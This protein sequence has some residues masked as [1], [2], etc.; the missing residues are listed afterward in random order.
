MKFEIPQNEIMKSWILLCLVMIRHKLINETIAFKNLKSLK[1][2]ILK[3]IFFFCKKL[4]CFFRSQKNIGKD[5]CHIPFSAPKSWKLLSFNG[6]PKTEKCF[7]IFWTRNISFPPSFFLSSSRE[8]S[9]GCWGRCCCCRNRLFGC[10]DS[11]REVEND[12]FRKW[13]TTDFFSSSSPTHAKM[14]EPN[15]KNKQG[16]KNDSCLI[17]VTSTAK[18]VKLWVH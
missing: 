16:H 7:F 17:L 6:T 3:C 10:F 2:D 5:H 11:R 9:S 12:T 14:V 15:D 18:T 8:W 1:F 4:R 13:P